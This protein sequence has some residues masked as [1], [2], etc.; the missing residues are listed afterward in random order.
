MEPQQLNQIRTEISSTD[1]QLLELL[2]KR[3]Q[4]SL[5]VAKSKLATSK[6]VRDVEREQQLLVKLI[7]QGKE[8]ELDA[9]YITQVFHTIIEDSVLQQQAFLQHHLN[10]ETIASKVRVAFIG[11][12]GSYSHLAAQRYF[13]RRAE[14]II[15]YGCSNFKEIIEKAETGL[16]DYAM[17][18]IENTSSGNINEVY[19]VLQ[20]TSLYI[21]GELS[22]P[23]E[24]CLLAKPGAAED[25]ISTIYAQFQ[26]IAQCSDYLE[27]LGEGVTVERVDSSSAAM[28]RVAERDSSEVAAIGNA[29]G[30]RL[31]GLAP[32]RTGIA[33]QKHNYSR[34]IV[35][36][37]KR[38][39]VAEQIPAKTS[40]MMAVK[41][42]P[43]A[44]VEALIT[45]KQHD[46]NMSK[47]E[48]RPIPGN[49]W[50]EMFYVDVDSN[51]ESEN[52][53]A[54]LK[55]LDGITTFLKILGCYP[56]DDIKAVEPD[57]D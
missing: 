32:L 21:V 52:L 47:L 33:N 4:L 42:R 22:V 29:D 34:F 7:E 20:H 38:V 41:Q 15:E 28:K 1:Q 14:E 51:V 44:L 6:P 19:D 43:G 46:I 3:R 45:L 26:P 50:E 39:E 53:K 12:Q 8:L 23:V 36:A 24:H 5:Q 31:Y 54:A 9:A 16:A 17:L 11:Q 57:I 10:P 48:S 55:E 49:P 27:L 30:G 35:L 40:F 13:A 2:S 37:R 25:K 18:P 56:S